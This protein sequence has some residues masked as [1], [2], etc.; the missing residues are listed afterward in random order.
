LSRS[1]YPQKPGRGPLQ[2]NLRRGL[3]LL[4]RPLEA[5]DAPPV[6]PDRAILCHSFTPEEVISLAEYR[7]FSSSADC[8]LAQG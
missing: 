8:D 2:W 3:W 4:L 1:S 7:P 5:E 6:L